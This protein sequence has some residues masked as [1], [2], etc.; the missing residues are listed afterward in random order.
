MLTIK[1]ISK[2]VGRTNHIEELIQR[3]QR[4]ERNDILIGL[5]SILCSIGIGVW[6]IV[7]IFLM[8]THR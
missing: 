5:L 3:K 2:I 7:Q 8:G 4:K 1:N 6:M